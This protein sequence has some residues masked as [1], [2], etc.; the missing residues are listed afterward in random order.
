MGQVFKVYNKMF[1]SEGCDFRMGILWNV[2]QTSAASA[3]AQEP[4]LVFVDMEMVVQDAEAH[5]LALDWMGAGSFKCRPCCWNVVSKNCNMVHDPTGTTIPIYTADTRLF[6]LITNKTFRNIQNR[7]KE[8]A[9]HRTPTELKDK[10]QELGFKYNPHSWLQDE[11]LDVQAMDLIAFDVMH[12][13]CQ[14]GVWEIELAAFMGVLSK[15]GYGGRQLHVYLQQFMWPKAYA[16]GKELCKGSVQ[17]RSK[18]KDVRPN[19]SAAEFMSAGPAVRKW[20]EYVVKPRGLCPAHVESLLRC[21][22]VLDMLSQVHTGRVTSEMLADGMTKHYAAHVVAYGYTLFVPK[23]HYML[24][25]PAQLSRFKMLILCYVHERKHKV[26]KRFAVPLCPKKNDNRTLLEECTL[27]HL[28]AIKNPLLKP[29]LLDKVKANPAVVAALKANGFASAE[30]AL[31]GRTARVQGRSIQIGDVAL[32]SD[33]C[34]NTKVGEIYW[35]A[36]IGGEIVVGLSE[37]RL[38]STCSIYRKV[39]VEENFSII[40]SARLLQAMIFTPTAVGKI[41]TVIMP[42]L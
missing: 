22:D 4:S 12:C 42:A 31:T 28:V 37:W 1:F 11:E 23:H 34:V 13:W 27:A 30:T 6:K 8:Y 9:L 18:A 24:H 33:G 15:H 21:I 35:Y 7:L 17:E 3:Q 10:Q 14:G 38:K 16:S 32:F 2:P 20:V 39:R 19:G 41:A 36:E 25:I 5:Q 26:L 40:P 29:C